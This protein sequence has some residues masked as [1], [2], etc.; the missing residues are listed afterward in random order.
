MYSGIAILALRVYFLAP[1]FEW[2]INF[3]NSGLTWISKLPYAGISEIW[4][5]YWQLLLLFI[6]IAT[7]SIGLSYYKRNYLFTGF[8]I[9]LILQGSLSFQKINSTKQ[10]EIIFFGLRKHYAAAFIS[11]NSCILITDLSINDKN[12]EFFVKPALDQKRIYSIKFVK[13]EEE[14][15]A[16]NFIKQ[17][18]QL[19]SGGER[20]LLLD[21]TF[22]YQKMANRPSFDFI[23]VHNN[24]KQQI[25]L[26][27]KEISFKALIIDASN[28][29]YLISKFELQ[30]NLLNLPVHIL[31]KKP[32][33]MLN[34]K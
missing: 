14:F 23:W 20:F 22:N 32:A 28:K 3:T 30:A 8:F 2:L 33:I 11:G 16:P 19:I 13:W 4:L 15:K 6:L 25:E 34:Q 26:L 9:W 29:D 12:F 31:K 17:N 5:N 27:K 10:S 7:L 21:E 18:H 1:A 24:P